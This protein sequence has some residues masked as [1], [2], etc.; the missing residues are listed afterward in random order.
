MQQL[1]VI[2]PV[3][4]AA[5]GVFDSGSYQWIIVSADDLFSN[6]TTSEEVGV[7]NIA[8]STFVVTTDDNGNPVKL[9]PTR[10]SRVL[11]GGTIYQFV[12][13]DQSATS[14]ASG[15]Y[16]QLGPGMNR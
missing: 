14:H 7:Y 4:A 1:T 6:E 16:V 15:V 12:K 2:A 13:D 9:T 3:E 8:G 5:T 10:P 11:V